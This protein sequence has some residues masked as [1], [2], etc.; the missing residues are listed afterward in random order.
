MSTRKGFTPLDHTSFSSNFAK[1][2][3]D[4]AHVTEIHGVR[5]KLGGFEVLVDLN[6]CD[7]QMNL[8]LYVTKSPETLFINLNH[9]EIGARDK[10]GVVYGTDEPCIEWNERQ[11]YER[12]IARLEGI[13]QTIE[14]LHDAAA[15]DAD[16]AVALRTFLDAVAKKLRNA[17][18]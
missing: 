17:A 5:L 4:S 15:R 9:Y 11:R 14:R 16:N 10:E 2:K 7:E 18:A 1:M 3:P 12:E 8:A 6:E 13:V